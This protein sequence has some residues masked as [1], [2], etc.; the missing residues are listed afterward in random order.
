[1]KKYFLMFIGIFQLTSCGES[2]LKFEGQGLEEKYLVF[3]GFERVVNISTPPE[4]KKVDIGLDYN[5]SEPEFEF[6]AKSATGNYVHGVPGVSSMKIVI[7]GIEAEEKIKT[8][9]KAK[10]F[11]GG[12]KVSLRV[13]KSPSGMCNV[14]S[15][16]SDDYMAYK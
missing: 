16:V 13:E 5:P 1:M 4:I 9:I 12:I 15:S 2:E 3:P 8:R 6:S 7:C 10:R 11:F 14:K